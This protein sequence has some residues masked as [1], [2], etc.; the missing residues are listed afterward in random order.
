MTYPLM[1]ILI[2]DFVIEE[3]DYLS[4]ILITVIDSIGKPEQTIGFDKKTIYER[5]WIQDWYSKIIKF[6][7][8]T[9]EG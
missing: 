1:F 3:N 8:R 2:K 9:R 4:Q 6:N 5:E 7:Y